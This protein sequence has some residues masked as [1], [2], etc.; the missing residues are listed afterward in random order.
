VTTEEILLMIAGMILLVGGL[1]FWVVGMTY[2]IILN[3][4]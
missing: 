2:G 4:F 3:F 1:S